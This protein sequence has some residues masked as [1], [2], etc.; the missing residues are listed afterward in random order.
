VRG[1]LEPVRIGTWAKP[2]AR[3]KARTPGWQ[4]AS[5]N[6]LACRKGKGRGRPH[7]RLDYIVAEPVTKGRRAELPAAV[8]EWAV[9]PFAVPGG[10]FV[11]PFAGSGALV[12]AAAG[13]GM[14]T[15]GCDRNTTSDRPAPAAPDDL[16]L[17]RG[18]APPCA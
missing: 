2:R 7:E 15:V 6:V 9:T 11:D 18:P 16:P 3:T 12:R 13:A 10:L 4:W 17:F 1:I 8:A 14:R 5:V